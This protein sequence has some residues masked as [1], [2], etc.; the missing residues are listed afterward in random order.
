MTLPP[1]K[2]VRFTQF[3]ALGTYNSDKFTVKPGELEANYQGPLLVLRVRRKV[4]EA[5][6]WSTIAIPIS[7]GGIAE[8]VH[9]DVPVPKAMCTAVRNYDICWREDG[10][11][12]DHDF[13]PGVAT[14]PATA[15]EEQRAAALD[16]KVEDL[17]K[18]VAEDMPNQQEP[19]RRGRPPKGAAGE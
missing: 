3:H 1:I 12:E 15:P 14:T 17:R 11:R 13:R 19:K 10:H 8:V 6:V 18:K 16:A 2:S 5:E 9:E 7:G 4:A